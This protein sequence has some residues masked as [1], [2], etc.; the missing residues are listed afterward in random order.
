MFTLEVDDGSIA[1][2]GPEWFVKQYFDDTTGV[3]MSI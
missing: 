2:V 3:F 1:D